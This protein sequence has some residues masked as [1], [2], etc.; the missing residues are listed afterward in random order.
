MLK[1]NEFSSL[2]EERDLKRMSLRSPP[3]KPASYVSPTVGCARKDQ[4]VET[5]KRSVVGAWR[6][7][8]EA[9]HREF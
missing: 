6:R 9:E 3:E 2:E 8:E 1:S 7:G 4:T 5:G